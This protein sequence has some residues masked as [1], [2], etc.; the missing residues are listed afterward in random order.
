MSLFCWH[1]VPGVRYL[2]AQTGVLLLMRCCVIM[3]S[4]MS[5]FVTMG[6]SICDWHAMSKFS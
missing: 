5:F 3:P 2:L 6:Y 1:Y 4:A